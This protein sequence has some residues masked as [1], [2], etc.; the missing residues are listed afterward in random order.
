[1][2]NVKVKLANRALIRRYGSTIIQVDAPEA[3][4]MI[5]RGDA[6]AIASD[7]DGPPMNKMVG[8]PIVKKGAGK[9]TE[10]PTEEEE[11]KEKKVEKKKVARPRK[12]AKKVVVSR[13]K[14][15]KHK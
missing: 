9:P 1:M 15:L 2:K 14:V 8:R 10:N 11:Q 7:F 6:V 4:R 13:K 12:T 5:K 3:A